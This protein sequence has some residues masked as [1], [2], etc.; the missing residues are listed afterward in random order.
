MKSTAKD[1]ARTGQQRGRGRRQ[2][3]KDRAAETR[4]HAVRVICE[5]RASRAVTCARWMFS[6]LRLASHAANIIWCRARFLWYIVTWCGKGA[7]A[8]RA[9]SRN[10]ASTW[11]V[12]R[13]GLC[14]VP[15][16]L[17]LA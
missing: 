5:R 6:C 8:M 2:H 7:G 13:A 11:R 12:S 17:L 9:G 3:S 1:V 4:E 10:A 16:L 15:R 14:A